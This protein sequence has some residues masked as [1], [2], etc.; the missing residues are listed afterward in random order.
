VIEV[1]GALLAVL[2]VGF[3]VLAVEFWGLPRRR[4]RV[5]VNFRDQTAPSISGI[6]WLR[7]G[8]WLLLR[9]CYLLETAKQAP[10]RIDG[11]VTLD[12]ASVL[13]IQ[14]PDGPLRR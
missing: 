14:V 10:T 13:F 12:R 5:I 2:A 8:R 7:R 4:H 11:E 3:G 1:L 9:D 6:L